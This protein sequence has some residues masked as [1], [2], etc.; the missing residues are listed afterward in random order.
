[1]KPEFQ[2]YLEDIGV[3]KPIQDRV[4]HFYCLCRNMVFEN[5][6]GI[7]VD[8]YLTQDK[9]RVYPGLSFYSKNL[10]FSIPNFITENMILI[11]HHRNL[12]DEINIVVENFDFKKANAKSLLMVEL[13]RGSVDTGYYKASQKNCEFLLR[14]LRK[15]VLPGLKKTDVHISAQP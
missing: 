3:T 11:T 7:F 1:M 4:E 13:R 14:I 8:D 6:L 2:K 5:L 12:Q 15:Y 9:S 10:S